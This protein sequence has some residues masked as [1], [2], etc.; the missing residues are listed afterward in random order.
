[1]ENRQQQGW[2][3]TLP[4]HGMLVWHIDQDWDIWQNNK[5][6]ADP[7]H[8]R[9]DIVE[10]DKVQTT[11]SYGGDPFPGTGHVTTYDFYSWAREN[12]FSFDWVEEND[13]TVRF[14]LAH[15]AYKP[16]APTIDVQQ[17]LG[18]SMTF[19]W[20]EVADA[21]G[22]LV[23]V[24]QLGADGTATALEGYDCKPYSQPQVV[25]VDGLTPQ[26]NYRITVV[27][28]IA[29]YQ[30]EPAVA[31]VATT[32]IQFCETAPVAT[33]ATAVTAT[34]FT[35]HWLPLD[36]AET[37]SV[38]VYSNAFSDVE[39]EAYG[40][41]HKADSLPEGWSTS[42]TQYST[43]MF[44]QSKPSLQ[45]A[46][47]DDYIQFDYAGRQIVKLNFW[48]RS[49][50]ASNQ[51]VV[52]SRDSSDDEWAEVTTMAMSSSG[53]VVSLDIDSVA[54]LRIRFD[55]KGSYALLDDIEV[56]YIT[57]DQSPVQG[58]TDLNAGDNLQ[59]AVS[60][61][62]RAGSYV[63]RVRGVQAGVPSTESNAVTVTMGEGVTGD[64]TGDGQVD[65]ADVNAVINVM[66]GKAA[67]TNAADVTGDGQ[68]DIADVNSVINLMLGKG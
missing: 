13:T 56:G 27:S 11:N 60:G 8:Q 14:L 45:L 15:T 41:D 46:K 61:L 1:M 66:L 18:Q 48:Q 35:A 29:S 47:Q 43:I 49:Q 34:G 68:V 51:L 3:R 23:T 31:Q 38:T 42:S 50:M 4:G 54:Q 28:K 22:Y 65:I 37:Y 40:F 64:V 58:F 20:C 32:E 25:R 24:E 26:Y 19:T 7:G 63:Y 21:Q 62:P 39:T 16:Q 9:I 52:E 10:A 5:A 57:L 59:L 55:R 17:V 36:G 30:S 33:E 67:P 53:E 44:G 6:N 12:L 2:D